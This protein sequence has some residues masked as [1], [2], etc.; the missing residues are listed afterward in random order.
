MRLIKHTDFSLRVLIY[1]SLQPLGKLVNN[2][3]I[4]K[5][6]LIKLL[7]TAVNE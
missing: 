3:E 4:T 1:L 6:Y 2:N 5:K 7:P